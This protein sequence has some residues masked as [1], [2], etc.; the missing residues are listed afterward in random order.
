MSIDKE[1][2]MDFLVNSHST[3]EIKQK[4]KDVHPNDVNLL[5]D[6]LEN[7]DFQYYD[8]IEKFFDILRTH[9]PGIEA[10][11]ILLS[12]KKFLNELFKRETFFF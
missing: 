11:P 5:I 3:E 12:I 4:Y 2:L 9:L 1:D 10:D 6:E 8:F 7:F